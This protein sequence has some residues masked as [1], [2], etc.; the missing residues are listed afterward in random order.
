FLPKEVA[1][2][3]EAWVAKAKDT[4][5]TVLAT[6]K[7][8]FGVPYLWGG[9]S[10]K[11]MDCS[12]F[13]KTVYFLNGVLLPRDANQQWE[14]GDVVDVQNGLENLRMGDLLFFGFKPT[15]EKKERI[16]HVGIYLGNKKFIHESGDV[17][18][19]S[20]EQSDPDFNEFRFN[21][22]LY[23]KRI[24]GAGSHTGVRRLVEQ[25]YYRGNEL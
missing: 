6:A 10:P 1:Q 3:Y 11:G 21:T 24:I 23:A 14:I 15:A 7:R 13:T 17:H 22:F 19:N 9:T 16:T 20:F 18:V 25:P 2:P 8:F 4:P 12:G 5:E